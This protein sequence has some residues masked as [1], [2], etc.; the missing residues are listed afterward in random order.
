ML[1]C[2]PW[3]VEPGIDQQLLEPN[4]MVARDR[5]TLAQE[6]EHVTHRVGVARKV[7]CLGAARVCIRTNPA[8][9]AAARSGRRDRAAHCVVDQCRAGI[10]C[11][12][13]RSARQ[14]S[15]ETMTRPPSA[16]AQSGTDTRPPARWRSRVSVRPDRRRHRRCPRPTPRARSSLYLCRHRRGVESATESRPTLRMPITTGSPAGSR[17]SCHGDAASPGVRA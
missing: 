15:T 12:G 4:A 16:L 9:D 5:G 17:A 2:G 13:D 11:S 14:V 10:D 3:L 7:F 6:L 8:P 1:S